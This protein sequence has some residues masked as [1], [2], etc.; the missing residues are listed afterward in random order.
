MTPLETAAIR[1][2]N[3]RIALYMS[4]GSDPAW[5]SIKAELEA[6]E[7]AMNKEVMKLLESEYE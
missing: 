1:W 3:A 5:E 6:C 7:E 4:N 2:R